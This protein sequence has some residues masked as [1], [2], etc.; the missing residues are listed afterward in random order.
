MKHFLV[1]NYTIDWV[2]EN[3]TLLYP[4]LY[5]DGSNIEFYPFIVAS[6]EFSVL[7]NSFNHVRV[8]ADKNASHMLALLTC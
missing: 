6:N 1:L 3:G 4:T 7:N 5:S 2:C 8:M